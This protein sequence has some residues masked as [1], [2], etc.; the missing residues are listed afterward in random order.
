M[1]EF[2]LNGEYSQLKWSAR[3]CQNAPRSSSIV[4]LDEFHSEQAETGNEFAKSSLI[5]LQSFEKDVVCSA[6]RG[7]TL[8]ELLV[9]IAII[10]VLISLL[11]PAVQAA[12]EAARRTQC[13]N[14][15]KQLGLAEHNY[16][17]VNHYFT[18]AFLLGYGPGLKA[19]L[20]SGPVCAP[21]C[22]LNMHMWGEKLLPFMEATTVYSRIDQNA[23]A[24]SP[25]TVPAPLGGQVF[26][27][28][29]SGGCS[30]LLCP[31]GPQ[32]PMAAVI[33]AFVCPSAP[34]V[35]NPFLETSA[36]VDCLIHTATG[37][38]AFVPTVFAG[39]SDYTAVNKY[40]NGLKK[41]YSATAGGCEKCDH[42]IMF[43]DNAPISIEQVIDGTSTTILAGE[44]AGRPDLW[45]RGVKKSLCCL[46]I[47]DGCIPIKPHHNSGGCWD[48]LESAFNEFFGST[49]A[50]T[51]PAPTTGVPVCFMNCTNQSFS[52][53]YS[54]HPGAC[55]LLMADGSGHMVSENM[56]VVVFCRL[57]SYRG[58]APVTDGF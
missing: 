25:M 52:G 35:A 11:L 16:S 6:R 36:L 38:P 45:Q 55:G 43:N 48:C 5:S 50:G 4:P 21:K 22:D 37:L 53:L 54:F 1:L 26:T 9:V 49:Y 8:I 47:M 34:R 19:I 18:P 29:N 33:P 32:R 20:G 28:P 57:I 17:D 10:A 31:P 40:C 27:A 46:Q 41:Y 30:P 7:F 23:A 13:R 12:R 24:T 39:A 14:N 56:S 3:T 2:S 58:Y 44:L 42:G 15:L 51:G